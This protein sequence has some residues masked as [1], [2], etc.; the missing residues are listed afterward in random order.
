FVALR[1]ALRAALRPGHNIVVL[2]TFEPRS[3]EHLL[4]DLIGTLELLLELLRIDV[5]LG[6]ARLLWHDP[7]ELRRRRDVGV[8]GEI[9]GLRHDLLAFAAEDEIREQHGRMRMFCA[10]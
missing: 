1:A 8:G 4:N 10:P 7:G 9:L 3:P 6:I 2:W 5:D